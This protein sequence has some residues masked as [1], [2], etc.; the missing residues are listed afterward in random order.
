M[1]GC[2]IALG[3]PLDGLLD[4]V[5]DGSQDAATMRRMVA[6]AEDALDHLGDPLG[7]PD[8]PAIAKRLRSLCQHCWQLGRL[9]STQLR[10]GA[11]R[12]MTTQ[13]LDSLRPDSFEPLADRSFAH[14]QGH[15]YV[16]L[17]PTLL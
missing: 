15:G 4:T 6:D 10:L 1:D 3:R 14:S 16:F 11:R 2:L 13:R 17:L 8:L 7:G 5:L 9:L 12:R